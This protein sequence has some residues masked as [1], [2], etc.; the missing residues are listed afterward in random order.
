LTEKGP[1]LLSVFDQT[2]LTNILYAHERIYGRT[3][4]CQ[5]S[6]FPFIEHSI[7]HTFYN[8]YEER[9]KPLIE[10][11]KLI[12]EFHRLS[13][14]DKMRLIRNSFIGLATLNESI[15]NG[16]IPQTL[17]ASL[18]NLYGTTITNNLIHMIERIRTLR[19]DPILL[20]LLIIIWLLSTGMNKYYDDTDMGRIFDDSLAIFAGQSIYVE[21]LW[22]YLVSRLPSIPDVVKFFNKLV[23]NLLCLQRGCFGAHRT[24]YNSENEIHKMKPLIQSMYI[25][26]K[27]IDVMDCDDTNELISIK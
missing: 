7:I 27:K 5:Y 14:D 25:T 20:K 21:L 19:C 9:C 24:M 10:Y 18:K 22:R 12:P 26:S 1:K 6:P 3:D 4:G 13:I 11:F 17:P 16:C 2:L 8:E 23:L 15:L